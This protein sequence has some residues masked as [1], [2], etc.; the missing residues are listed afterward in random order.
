MLTF[1]IPE[2]HCEGCIKSLTGALRRLDGKASL[3]ADLDTK[4]V[5]VETMANDTAV[6]AAFE[7]AGFTVRGPI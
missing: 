1:H 7:D 4:R 5:T 6:T 3:S 2:I